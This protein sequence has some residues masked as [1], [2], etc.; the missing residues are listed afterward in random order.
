[1]DL[2]KLS[3]RER[4]V[5]E[6]AV[7]TLRA[8]D[9][10]G[11]KAEYGKGMAALEGVIHDKGLRHLRDMLAAAANARPEAQ[12]RGPASGRVPGATAGAS[13]SSSR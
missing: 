1:M 10:A 7:L 13:S 3:E 9:E 8:L 5:A 2:S 11:D 12:K 4:L 6:Q